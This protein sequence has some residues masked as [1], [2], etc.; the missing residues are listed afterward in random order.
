MHLHLPRLI[1]KLTILIIS[2]VV[3]L[4]ETVLFE[5]NL[6]GIPDDA[7]KFDKP[8]QEMKKFEVKGVQM[9][10]STCLRRAISQELRLETSRIGRYR[11]YTKSGTQVVEYEVVQEGH[12]VR[13]SESPIATLCVSNV[14]AGACFVLVILSPEAFTYEDEQQSSSEILPDKFEGK[15]RISGKIIH[16]KTSESNMSWDVQAKSINKLEVLA[17]HS[18]LINPDLCERDI[19]ITEFYM[20]FDSAKEIFD[21]LVLKYNNLKRKTVLPDISKLSQKVPYQ[22]A[23]KPI[24]FSVIEGSAKIAT[25]KSSQAV[26][27]EKNQKVHCKICGDQF[28]IGMIRHHIASHIKHDPE[29]EDKVNP[30]PISQLCCMCGVSKALTFSPAPDGG[31]ALWQEKNSARGAWKVNYICKNVSPHEFNYATAIKFSTNAPSTNVPIECPVC[32]SERKR[33]QV[34]KTQCIPKYNFEAHW[35]QHHSDR[36]MD[37]YPGLRDLVQVSNEEVKRLRDPKFATWLKKEKKNQKR[38]LLVNT[39]S[40]LKSRKT[41]IMQ[42][43]SLG[44]T[45]SAIPS[46]S[47]TSSSANTSSSDCLPEYSKIPND[48]SRASEATTSMTISSEATTSEATTSEATASHV[49]TSNTT[50]SNATSSEPNRSTAATGEATPSNNTTSEITVRC[51]QVLLLQDV[52]PA[53]R[54]KCDEIVSDAIVRK[55]NRNIDDPEYVFTDKK[56]TV[57]AIAKFYGT[58]FIND[59]AM[60]MF[61]CVVNRQNTESRI[62]DTTYPKCIIVNGWIT[63]MMIGQNADSD[64]I[65]FTST[66]AEGYKTRR[67]SRCRQWS[68]HIFGQEVGDECNSVPK[69]VTKKGVTMMIFQVNIPNYHWF[70]VAVDFVEKTITVY[71]SMYTS[72]VEE[73][74]KDHVVSYGDNILSHLVD[75]KLCELNENDLKSLCSSTSIKPGQNKIDMVRNLMRPL[76]VQEIFKFLQ[77]EN[78]NEDIGDRI[79]L[80]NWRLAISVGMASQRSYGNNCAIYTSAV[81]EIL[82]SGRNVKILEDYSDKIETDGRCRMISILCIEYGNLKELKQMADPE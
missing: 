22:Y 64:G 2:L 8:N 55:K 62:K 58:E 61:I 59:E 73:S 17:E 10:A 9:S 14:A 46:A 30:I 38:Q 39:E 82:S 66:S 23:N 4:D 68:K 77:E 33:G 13:A 26:S 42:V 47:N 49:I 56:I 21:R 3:D 50:T 78:S 28:E 7:G 34:R 48:G 12:A 69:L 24:L 5:E 15:T 11:G 20:S 70:S 80:E 41:S 27:R 76:I 51:E 32:S 18:T 43:A 29:L 31:C 40:T 44:K 53:M 45:S 74:E 52:T 79:D 35:N 19:G 54:V 75:K 67:K 1:Q 25:S 37:D 71:D 16:V 65:I 81:T 60:D 36:S 6:G 63:S 57:S 72:V